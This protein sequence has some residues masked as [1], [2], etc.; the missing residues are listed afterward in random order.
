MVRH[1][2]F[3]L[4]ALVFFSSFFFATN[5]E[6]RNQSEKQLRLKHK[7]NLLMFFFGEHFPLF[8]VNAVKR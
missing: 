5:D 3:A 4:K 8:L 7:V 6:K 1:R 2:Q